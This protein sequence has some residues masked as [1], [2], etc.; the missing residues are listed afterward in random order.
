MV[1]IQVKAAD[2]C[3]HDRD[4]SGKRD[5]IQRLD[6]A[7]APL[8]QRDI[9]IALAADHTT[10]SNS[11]FHTADPVPAFVFRPGLPSARDII[12]FGE[13]A[14][15]AGTMPRQSSEMF[16][17]RVLDAMGIVQGALA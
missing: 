10:D 11:G 4:P 8:L 6:A 9:V 1:I 7:I 14:C 15:R 16:L 13:Q 3:A 17:R 12:K 5:F 2:I